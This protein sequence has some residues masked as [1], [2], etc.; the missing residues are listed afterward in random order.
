VLSAN[1]RAWAP[2]ARRVAQTPS[3]SANAHKTSE[4]ASSLLIFI[5]RLDMSSGRA[6]DFL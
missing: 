5:V 2:L 1:L 4:C 6:V 3:L